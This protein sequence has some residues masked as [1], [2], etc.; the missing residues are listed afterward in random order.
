[1]KAPTLRDAVERLAQ[2]AREQAWSHEEFGSTVGHADLL[3]SNRAAACP[4]GPVAHGGC[5][6]PGLLQR[7]NPRPCRIRT[8]GPTSC[9]APSA[10]WTRWPLAGRTSSSGSGG[11]RPERG[12]VH[13]RRE[14]RER[15]TRV[16]QRHVERLDLRTPAWASTRPS[17]PQSTFA[18]APATTSERR[19]N[20]RNRFSSWPPRSASIRG[21]AS[22]RFC[23]TR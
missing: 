19:C 22:A 3:D 6:V 14:Y 7:A 20:P 21:R 11:C 2:R 18:C 8:A 1:M 10:A 4:V 5:C 9:G 17:S 23:L 12:H 16:R 15:V 13:A